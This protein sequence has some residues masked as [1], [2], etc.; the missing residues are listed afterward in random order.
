ME[1]NTPVEPRPFQG[2]IIVRQVVAEAVAALW[3]PTVHPH[4]WSRGFP[5]LYTSLDLDVA[6]AERLK[7]TGLRR[8]RLAVGLARASIQRTVDLSLDAS[9]ATVGASTQ[10]VTGLDYTVPQ[11]IGRELFEGGVAALLVPAAIAEVAQHYPRFRLVQDRHVEE[12]AT[13]GTGIHLVIFPDNLE[14]GDGY[15]EIERFLCEILGMAE[16]RNT[17]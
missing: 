3:R 9:L 7:R 8:T 5:A 15:P 14:R 2:R 4:R 12:R 17:P 11:R 1:R 6:I 16:G 10:G 13:P